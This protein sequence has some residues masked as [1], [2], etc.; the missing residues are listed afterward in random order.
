MSSA[1]TTLSSWDSRIS[2][3]EA[4]IAALHV[5]A[6]NARR[7]RNAVLPINQL[8]NEILVLIFLQRRNSVLGSNSRGNWKW[9]RGCL[10]VCFHWRSLCLSTPQLW[11]HIITDKRE[12]AVKAAMNLTQLPF[13]ITWRGRCS[14]R[15]PVR[16]W[17]L[18]SRAAS[19]EFK[20][21]G[22]EFHNFMAPIKGRY[23]GAIFSAPYLERIDF[24]VYEAASEVYD[25][26][27]PLLQKA[28]KLRHISLVD[29]REEDDFGDTNDP[30]ANSYS[31]SSFASSFPNLVHLCLCGEYVT[32]AVNGED[33]LSMFPHLRTLVLQWPTKNDSIRFLQLTRSA[34]PISLRIERIMISEREEIDELAKEASICLSSRGPVQYRTLQLTVYNPPGSGFNKTPYIEIHLAADSKDEFTISVSMLEDEDIEFFQV[35]LHS[36][37]KTFNTAMIDEVTFTRLGFLLFQQDIWAMLMNLSVKT[38]ILDGIRGEF[39]NQLSRKPGVQHASLPNLRTVILRNHLRIF[40]PVM[41]LIQFLI[42]RRRETAPTVQLVIEGGHPGTFGLPGAFDLGVLLHL[43][44][45]SSLEYIPPGP[46]MWEEDEAQFTDDVESEE[47]VSG[48]LSEGWD[49]DEFGTEMLYNEEIFGFED[50]DSDLD[51]RP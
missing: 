22:H 11:D 24:T 44:H 47:E 14:I 17:Q 33:S 46:K 36:I 20:G 23:R 19:I 31:L 48:G 3:I 18:L 10:N 50:D 34:I 12:R 7:H 30:V 49:H 15:E 25:M 8:P 39:E 21:E 28:P 1:A 5:E 51:Y 32:G 26:I 42:C 2:D 6:R 37:L 41:S 45:I 16:L 40:F 43:D 27:T 38:L 29:R 9:T 35:A 4:Q 13:Q